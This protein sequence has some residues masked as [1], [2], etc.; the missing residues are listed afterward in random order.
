M[1][2]R[3]STALAALLIAGSGI[4]LAAPAAADP[5]SRLTSQV[6]DRVGALEGGQR[7]VDDALRQLSDEDRQ[8]LWVVYV[9]SFDG[10]SGEDWARQT[11]EASGFGTD[12]VLLAV[13]VD[14]SAYAYHVSDS[15][16]LTQE[17]L[18]QV[19]RDTETELGQEDWSG[20]VVA[21]A[22]S[23]GD[24][25][26]GGTGSSSGSTTS[27]GSSGAGLLVLVLVVLVLLGVVVALV[28]RAR[29][30]RGAGS[31]PAAAGGPPD[32]FAGTST[33]DLRT[34]AD[35]TLVRADD[36]VRT[37]GQELE[38]AR[39]EFGEEATQPFAAALAAA[40]AAL[41]AA[42]QQ[43]Q[44]LDDDEPD[45]DART[46]ALL[47]SV[48]QSC[49]QAGAA[50]D[51]ESGRIEELRDLVATAPQRLDAVATRLP[52][53]EA[54]VAPARAEL[55]RLAA[56]FSPTALSS[57]AT[58]PDEALRRTA[59]AREAVDSG[60]AAIAA[61]TEGDAVVDAVRTAEEASAQAAQLLDAVGRAG[62]DLDRAT[63][64][65][66]TALLRL[67]TDLDTLGA[68]AQDRDLAQAAAAARAAVAAAEESGGVDP[69]G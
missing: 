8:Q 37:S 38:F 32:P 52:E 4:A 16:P 9:G 17:E 43:R 5:P 40:K 39:A 65:L 50:L 69:L 20:A 30:R 62:A 1:R 15:S 24:Q 6:T 44:L 47:T 45:D 12:D 14:D 7:E 68:A 18:T 23:I 31:G 25:V 29:H 63:A 51:A 53:L 2:R 56:R 55:T 42:F 67:R 11:F 36:A 27:G 26:G 54:R 49:E 3:T 64:E 19:S 41:T 46:R 22:Q 35:A 60:R 61:T 57:V 28:L 34:R 21:G 33:A 58:N 13:A 59:A 10:I 66:P 48:L